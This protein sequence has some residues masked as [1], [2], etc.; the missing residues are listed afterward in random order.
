MEL[1][2]P[3]CDN[4]CPG[5]MQSE[6]GSHDRHDHRVRFS[7]L[8]SGHLH[9]GRQSLRD[10]V[11]DAS[12][13][14][15]C[16]ANG[17]GLPRLPLRRTRWALHRC[18]SRRRSLQACRR[19]G[20]L[21]TNHPGRHSEFVPVDTASWRPGDA[22]SVHGPH[23]ARRGTQPRSAAS[24]AARSAPLPGDE[25]H[26]APPQPEPLVTVPSSSCRSVNEC[27]HGIRLWAQKGAEDRPR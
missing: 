3:L 7:M 2:G 12:I 20:A 27:P 9:A 5:S 4:P 22:R 10:G 21:G 11:P 15:G 1:R 18:D 25:D 16:P 23:N 24:R 17:Q 19:D 26:Q 13:T 14:K 6:L 8:G